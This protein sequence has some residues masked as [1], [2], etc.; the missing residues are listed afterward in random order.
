MQ[1][2]KKNEVNWLKLQNWRY[3]YDI[4]EYMSSWRRQSS[5]LA[6][7]LCAGEERVK[8]KHTSREHKVQSEKNVVYLF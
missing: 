4:V 5:Q 2:S 3:T 8:K 1:L 7:R 6:G